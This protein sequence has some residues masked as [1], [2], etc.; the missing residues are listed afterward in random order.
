MIAVAYLE[1]DEDG[2]QDFCFFFEGEGSSLGVKAQEE[3]LDGMLCLV[4]PGLIILDAVV[5]EGVEEKQLAVGLEAKGGHW[6]I[7]N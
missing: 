6:G 1:E 3:G 5:S 4:P 7:D 2:E